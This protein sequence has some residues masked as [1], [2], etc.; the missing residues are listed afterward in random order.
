MTEKTCD[1]PDGTGARLYTLSNKNGLSTT[2][3]NYGGIIV[4]LMVP[5]KNRKMEDIVLGYEKIED[6]VKDSPYFGAL[7]GRYG[8]RIAKGEFI[9]KEDTFKLNC[10]NYPID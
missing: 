8:N 9:L 6:Y 10:N 3:T 4:D 2:V 5:D 7:I 1:L